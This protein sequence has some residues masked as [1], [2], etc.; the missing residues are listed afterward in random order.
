MTLLFLFLIVAVADGKGSL[1]RGVF[2]LDG[3]KLL[4]AEIFVNIQ[5]LLLYPKVDIQLDK[6][7]T[8]LQHMA[9]AD[10]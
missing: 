3:T 9:N 7:A 1:E 5:F 2:S 6:I 4:L 8:E 10:P